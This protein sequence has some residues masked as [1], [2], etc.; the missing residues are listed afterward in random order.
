[1]VLVGIVNPFFI[2]SNIFSKIYIINNTKLSHITR[3]CGRLYYSCSEK[4][5]AT[6]KLW[7]ERAAEI[8][9]N[10]PPEIRS[11]DAYFKIG[12]GKIRSPDKNVHGRHALYRSS[13]DPVKTI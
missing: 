4:N 12:R 7:L 3:R 5:A 1:M 10:N 6:G 9:K 13:F 11:D 2:L 8:R